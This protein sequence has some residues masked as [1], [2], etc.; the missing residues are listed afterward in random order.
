MRETMNEHPEV[1]D[2]IQQSKYCLSLFSPESKI[3]KELLL[4]KTVTID[5]IA[6]FFFKK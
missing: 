6:L 5:F 3:L 2:I 4:K 1:K